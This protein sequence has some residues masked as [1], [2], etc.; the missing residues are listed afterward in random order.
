MTPKEV[1]DLL[2]SVLEAYVSD[3]SGL[4]V[5]RIPEGLA[6]IQVNGAHV[7]IRANRM[8]LEVAS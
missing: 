1:I 2:Q 6:V 7:L 3:R 4:H 8:T 5:V